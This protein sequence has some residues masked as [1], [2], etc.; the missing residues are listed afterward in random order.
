VEPPY[1]TTIDL[2]KKGSYM[3]CAAPK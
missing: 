3:S 1:Y 2:V